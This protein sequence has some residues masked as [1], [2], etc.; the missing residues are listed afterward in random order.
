MLTDGIMA[1]TVYWTA[2]NEATS[3][4]FF[5]KRHVVFCTTVLLLPLSATHGVMIYTQ[6]PIH[7]L[8][9]NEQKWAKVVEVKDE[10]DEFCI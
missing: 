9:K 5:A 8:L 10:G 1:A 6:H 2:V 3:A 4:R 7:I